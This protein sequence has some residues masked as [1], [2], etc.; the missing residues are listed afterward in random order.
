MMLFAVKVT[1]I[2]SGSAPGI[3]AWRTRSSSASVR[4]MGI[5]KSAFVMKFAPTIK[6]HAARSRNRAASKAMDAALLGDRDWHVHP[7]FVMPRRVTGEFHLA[8]RHWFAE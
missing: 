5:F 8:R 6:I 4:L 1:T 2:F 7:G 3:A